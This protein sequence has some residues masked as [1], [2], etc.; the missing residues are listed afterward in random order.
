M[1][2]VFILCLLFLPTAAFS[3]IPLGIGVWR[4]HVPYQN[5]TSL[6]DAGDR[7]YLSGNV[8]FFSYD[9]ETGS[10]QR[11]DKI[12]GLSDVG[13]SLVSYNPFDSTLLV[14]YES[15]NID[16]IKR[17][18]IINISDIK[19]KQIIGEK[20]INNVF[21]QNN[22]AYLS[23]DFG[24]VVLDMDKL[25]IKDTYR[26]GNNGSDVK[27]FSFS[28]DNTNFYAATEEGLKIADKNSFNLANY[29]EWVLAQGLPAKTAKQVVNF[30][31]KIFASVN[32][33]LYQR[34][35]NIWDYYY[36]RSQWDIV[37]LTVANNH[38]TICESSKTADFVS[39]I[40]IVGSDF[41]CCDSSLFK[42]EIRNPYQAYM[43][44]D[45][46]IWVADFLNGLLR[47]KDG[48]VYPPI[49]PQGQPV[50]ASV[51]NM[52]AER[53]ELWVAPGGVVSFNY[54]YN[55]DGAFSF[56]DNWWNTYNSY[57]QPQIADTILS[58]YDVAVHP[59]QNKTYLASWYT[60]L[61]EYDGTSFK[62]YDPSNSILEP[63]ADAP[64]TII[65]GL[66][67]DSRENLW[68]TSF[69]AEHPLI[70]K[71]ADGTWEHY[72]TPGV[73]GNWLVQIIVDDYDQKWIT[74]PKSNGQGILVFKEPNQQRILK[75][76]QGSGN[77]PTNDVHC[78]VNDLEGEIWVGTGQGIAVFYCPGSVLTS[79]GCDA[80][81]IIVTVNGVAGYLLETEN[82]GTIAVDGANRKWV[83]T[84]NGV[85]VLS[86]DGTQQIAYYTEENSPL[87]SNN[88]SD[89]TI[90]EKTG[91]VFIGTEK[92]IVSLRGEATEGGEE[93]SDVVV[94]PN[95]VREDYE[96]PIAIKGLVNNANV[97][98][99]DVNGMLFY[100]T[101]ALGGQ[102]VWDG[103]NYN[104]ERAKTGVYFIFTSNDDGSSKNVAKLL[105]IN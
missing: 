97:K 55:R 24:I 45:G 59:S 40:L 1:L 98:I 69:S 44:T 75:T 35:G 72:L 61:V 15:S 81:Q 28:A 65:S 9:K 74:L 100:E 54:G 46:T 101:T 105:I 85:F 49:Y 51:Q 13:V 84:T 53:N 90:N 91:E 22:L 93:H 95:P 32:D 43:D 23:C 2:R 31:E 39:R 33:T 104:G 86:P 41:I 7:I 12:S 20:K 102:A 6:T 48:N 60:G 14:A 47:I 19:R 87:L 21:F 17:N 37:N 73:D 26:I 62:L 79:D 88:I 4:I 80:Q 10:L 63:S 82:I 38:M 94:F 36:S 66:A 42:P 96:G 3:Q 64:R 89:I 76:G 77:L 8:F 92:G 52:S 11:F 30:D 70:V 71:R 57:T 5:V 50:T 16:L 67:F 78:L 58:L 18:N 34:N 68:I 83:G 27:V 25:E 99:N 29:S 103:R 56:Q